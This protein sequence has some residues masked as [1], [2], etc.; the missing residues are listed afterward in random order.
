MSQWNTRNR[1]S[2]R[3]CVLCMQLEHSYRQFFFILRIK[4]KKINLKKHRQIVHKNKYISYT[5]NGL[6][7]DKIVDQMDANSLQFPSFLAEKILWT[8]L[9]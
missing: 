5:H 1:K 4:K 7:I 8:F 3:V 6:L 2:V 9:N